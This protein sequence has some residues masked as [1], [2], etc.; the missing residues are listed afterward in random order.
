[1]RYADSVIAENGHLVAENRQLRE[2]MLR[3]KADLYRNTPCYLIVV[4]LLQ[5]KE[6]IQSN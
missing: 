3:L 2:E 4:N 5:E 6:H 1:M